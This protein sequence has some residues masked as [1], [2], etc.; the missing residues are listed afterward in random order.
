MARNAHG[1][2]SEKIPVFRKI[3]KTC[4]FRGF[5]GF[6]SE[7]ALRILLKLGQNVLCMITDHLQKTAYQNLFPFSRF[8]ILTAVKTR[9]N[10]FLGELLAGFI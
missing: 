10:A 5:F 2:F 8:R 9:K 1:G 6:F 7:T 3:A 4:Y